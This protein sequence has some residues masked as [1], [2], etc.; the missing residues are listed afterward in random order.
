MGKHISKILFFLISSI[1]LISC[2]PNQSEKGVLNNDSI[3]RTKV[4]N[5]SNGMG[6]DFI[7][8]LES[9]YGAAKNI[10]YTPTVLYAWEQIDS[11]LRCD[12]NLSVKPE[13]NLASILNSKSY[14]G[15][16]SKQ[17][18]KAEV[19]V[20]GNQIKAISSFSKSIPFKSELF[21]IDTGMMFNSIRVK[22]FGL[23]EFSREAYKNVK[24]LLYKNENC[25]I[26][27]IFGREASIFLAKGFN[28]SFSFADCLINIE[29][30]I[31][32]YE[33][34]IRKDLI[35]KMPN[36]YNS[37]SSVAFKRNLHD[38]DKIYI[39]EISF[40]L[41][42]NFEE[43]NG[44]LLACNQKNFTIDSINQRIS[45][46]IDSKGV[47]IEGEAEI[48]GSISIQ[49][50]GR[51][52]PLILRFDKPYLIYV[53]KKSDIGEKEFPPLFMMR[54]QNSDLMKKM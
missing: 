45:F 44:A 54:V 4:L 29:N 49:F 42:K 25:F 5:I 33:D 2:A 26:I 16:L 34:S 21:P 23:Q 50:S 35:K 43:F 24:L 14:I 9:K 31:K 46:G 15:S 22:C 51:P 10:I 41:K 17:D 3:M 8:S 47:K 20:S 48:S 11:L 38:S 32:N 37:N 12:S 30:A 18:Y 19:S 13:N 39:P 52:K 40:N 27:Q 36:L 53:R 7:I 28:N 1:L 6:S